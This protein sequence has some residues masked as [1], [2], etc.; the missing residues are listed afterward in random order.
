MQHAI[1]TP[2]DFDNAI[3]EARQHIEGMQTAGCVDAEQLDEL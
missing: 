3:E 2:E 1:Q